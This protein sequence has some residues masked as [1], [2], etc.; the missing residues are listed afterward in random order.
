MYASV[1]AVGVSVLLTASTLAYTVVRIAGSAYLIWLGGRLLWAALHAGGPEQPEPAAGSTSS[2]LR[3]A[4]L[5][6]LSTNGLNPKIGA[7]YVA[8]LPQFIPAHA[9]HLVAGLVLALVHDAEGMLWFSGIILAAGAARRWLSRR[10]ARRGIDGLTGAA[11][12]GFGLTLGG[13]GH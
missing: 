12:V 2:G 11:L 6:G 9:N 7:F 5:R 13:S 10:A 8:V 1:E 3:R 4:W